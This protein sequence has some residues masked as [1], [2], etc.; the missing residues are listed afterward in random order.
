MTQYRMPEQQVLEVYARLGWDKPLHIQYLNYLWN[1]LQGDL[2]ISI[3][4]NARVS[5]LVSARLAPTVFLAVYAT[6]LS[7]VI[8]MPLAIW[9]AARR[10]R[11]TDYAI[12]IAGMVGF[13]MP[14]FWIGLL[15]MIVFGLK[16]R[17]LPISGYG[18][19]FIGHLRH[20]FMPAL[21]LTFFLVPLFVQSLRAS[22]LEVMD[23]DFVEV[24][25]A[26][27]L[28][29]PRILTVHVLRNALI[30]LVTVVAINF[31]FLLGG[32]VLIESVFSLPGIGSLFIRAVGQRDYL[33][34][35]SL[36]LVFAA[37]V[38]AASL[39]ADVTY[40]LIDKRVTQT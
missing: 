16:L 38:V 12:R 1:L 5:D 14:A 4:A 2:G 11:L 40:S 18:D 10:D 13:A 34:V 9:A 28:S 29:E 37:G 6:L 22:M 17:W 39:L 30:P 24:A 8:A 35:Q 19:G 32:A 3:V 23:M 21:T 25:R 33:V 15:L 31:G 26:K 27:G 7:I 36:S 20:L